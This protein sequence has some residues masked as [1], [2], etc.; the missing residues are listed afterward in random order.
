MVKKIT[1]NVMKVIFT[2]IFQY[3]CY[4]M[5]KYNV[6]TVKIAAIFTD[7]FIAKVTVSLYS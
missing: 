1:I 7:N 3:K 2:L 4:K 6:P 5:T